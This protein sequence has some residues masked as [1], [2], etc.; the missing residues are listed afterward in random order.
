MLRRGLNRK[1][2]PP[3]GKACLE[4]TFALQYR[5]RELKDGFNPQEGLVAAAIR[6]DAVDER[7]TGG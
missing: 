3:H 2:A 4:C 5:A 1:G 6:L 7:T